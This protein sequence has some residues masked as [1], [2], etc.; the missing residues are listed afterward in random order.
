M[1]YPAALPASP[2]GSRAPCA[3]SVANLS[4]A[5]GSRSGRPTTKVS[6]TSN[7]RMLRCTVALTYSPTRTAATG[8]GGLYPTPYPDPGRR[9][10]GRT[11]RGGR[12]QPLPSRAPA[13]HGDGSRL[14]HPRDAHL[15]SGRRTARLGRRVQA[16]R[17]RW[18]TTG[19]GTRVRNRRFRRPLGAYALSRTSPAAIRTRVLVNCSGTTDIRACGPWSSKYRPSTRSDSGSES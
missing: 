13:L 16:S 6:T 7:T 10:R 14:P 2:L 12:T 5:L 11:P 17:T 8:S 15:R 3:G 19:F 9:T 1:T 4:P 18:C